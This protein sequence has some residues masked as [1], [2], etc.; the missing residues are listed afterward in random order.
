MREL[1]LDDFIRPSALRQLEQCP[2]AARMQLAV[3]Q[4][5]GKPPKEGATELGSLGHRWG[6]LGIRML[7][8][9]GLL[10]W[11][12]AE[13][14]A[15]LDYRMKAYGVDDWTRACIRKYVEFVA[16]L[17]QKH[18]IMPSNILVEQ[19]RGME[20]LGM[21]G[22]TTDVTLIVPFKRAI[23]V[24]LKLGFDDAG[25]ADEHAQVHAY[26]MQA[27]DDFQCSEAEAWIFQP[28]QEKEATGARFDAPTLRANAEWTRRIVEQARHPSAPLKAGYSHCRYCDCLWNCRTAKEFIMNASEML[29][30]IGDPDNPD[31]W[32]ILAD[33]AKLAQR[34]GKQAESM[35][36]SHIEDGGEATGWCLQ[37]MGSMIYI[38]ADA[39]RI[40]AG[41][42]AEKRETLL[43]HATFKVD[44]AKALPWLNPAVEKKPKAKSLRPVKVSS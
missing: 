31:A 12:V 15:E 11:P 30:V 9:H 21:E 5:F 38:D 27:A 26:A 17:I 32:G 18:G 3:V 23:I 2:G 7:K 33:A 14:N 42:D 36:K 41:D 43:T 4:K 39:A 34:F 44:A 8:R 16:N 1:T 24:D 19:R 29:T 13:V 35:V 10:C 37:S 28:R 22:G 6:A 40:L 20:S 25:D